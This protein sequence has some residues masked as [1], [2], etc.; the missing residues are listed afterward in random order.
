M[1][2]IHRY[3]SEAQKRRWLPEMAA[4]RVIGCYGLTEPDAGSDPGALAT[5]ARRDGDSWVI[6]GAKM[7]ITSSPLAQVAL[8]WAKVGADDSTCIRGFLVERGT[9][10]FSTPTM[11]GKL[12]L[13]SSC[14]GE[15]VLESCRVPEDALLP[16]AR[17]LGAPLSCL[18][19]AR[20][21]IAWGA[22]GAARACFDS[23]LQYTLDRPQFGGPIAGKQLV[24]AKLVEM[25]TSIATS[26][27]LALHVG[28]LKERGEATPYHVSLAKRHNV[29]SALEVAR[30]ARQLHGANGIMAEYSPIRHMLNLE[31]VIT[32]EGTHE[33]HTLIVGRGLTGIDAL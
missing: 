16:E 1:Y 28:R 13:R 18:N 8:V 25:A 26:R 27:L 3:G 14:T 6:D 19:Q 21:G 29:A 33:M 31:S 15:I 23:S 30:T 20:F 32:Y 5:R 2:G 24:Q 7:W 11:E 22:V 4:G 10:G 9:E 12:S 17:G